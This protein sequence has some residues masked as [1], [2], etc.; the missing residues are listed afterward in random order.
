MGLFNFGKRVRPQG[1]LYIPRYW[2][3]EKEE[4]NA[5]ITAARYA[6]EGDTD[7]MKSR[8]SAGFRKPRSY[9]K[10][11]QLARNRSSLIVL[12]TFVVLLVLIFLLILRFIPQIEQMLK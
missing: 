5:R 6:A 9:G 7:A 10:G 11:S 1:F 4:R 8:I 12:A 3:H 2:D